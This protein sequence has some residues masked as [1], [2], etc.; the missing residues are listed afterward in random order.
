MKTKA[1]LENIEAMVERAFDTLCVHCPDFE[2]YTVLIH[3]DFKTPKEAKSKAVCSIGFDD[4]QNS[5]KHTK[6]WA[7]FLH[8]KDE[9]NKSETRTYNPRN[10]LLSEVETIECDDVKIK[11]A[12]FALKK[13]PLA[14]DIAVNARAQELNIHKNAEFIIEFEQWYFGRSMLG[15]INP[16]NAGK[17]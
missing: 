4:L 6:V 14:L 10:V 11:D 9:A 5:L 2:L 12:V 17:K 7:D 8:P 3:V 16:A 15:V 1:F 13:R